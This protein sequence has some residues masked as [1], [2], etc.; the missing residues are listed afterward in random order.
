M[1]DAK[2][3]FHE[4]VEYSQDAARNYTYKILRVYYSL[5]VEGRTINN[6][7]SDVRQKASSGS[8]P[9]T[10]EVKPP[11]GYRG[12]L[13]AKALCEAVRKYCKNIVRPPKEVTEIPSHSNIPASSERIKYEMEVEL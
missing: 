13:D 8:E 3:I 12:E 10:I 2:V 9:D 4:L 6:L 5:E 7:F 11:P 1:G